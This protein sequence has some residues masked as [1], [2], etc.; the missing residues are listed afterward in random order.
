VESVPLSPAGSDRYAGQ[1]RQY[2]TQW[3]VLT[4]QPIGHIGLFRIR[5]AELSPDL[6]AATEPAPSQES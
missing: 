5:G 1:L 6:R 2:G 3:S 4:D